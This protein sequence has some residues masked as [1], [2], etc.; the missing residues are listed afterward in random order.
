MKH[1]ARRINCTIQPLAAPAASLLPF[2]VSS[3]F[4]CILPCL[5][6]LSWE[7]YG[8]A[9]QVRRCTVGSFTPS[10]AFTFN[11]N[12]ATNPFLLSCMTET[13]PKLTLSGKGDSDSFLHTATI[14]DPL[15]MWVAE[16]RKDPC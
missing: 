10:S 7:F 12:K 15:E 2:T 9:N 13:E 6:C 5:H 8:M 3:L 1:Q 14:L 16:R 11:G 4:S